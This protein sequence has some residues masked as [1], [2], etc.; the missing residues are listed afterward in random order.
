[1]AEN[2]TVVT[3]QVATLFL[4][5]GVGFVLFRRGSL[6]GAGIAQM[7]HLLLYVV[8]PC[9]V[10]N[11]LQSAWDAALLHNLLL[12]AA[13][14]ISAYLLYALAVL[15]LFRKKPPD[16]RA[17]LQFG[18]M[19]SNCGFMGLPLVQAVL[20]DGA[21]IYAALTVVCF[22]AF[23][24]IHGVALMGGREQ[25]SLKRAV[26]NPC[27]LGLAVGLPLFLLGVRLPAVLGDAVRFLSNLNTPLA[28][29]VIGGQMAQADLARTFRERELYGAACVKLILL[30]A[31]TALL[32][33]PFRLDP[34]MYA[35][36]VILCAAPT[37]GLTGM[38]A[39]RFGRSTA[40][41]AQLVTLSTLLS[42]L[43]LPPFAVLAKALAG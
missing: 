22:N 42:V 5:M 1:M 10:I 15:P 27:V 13:L 12:G 33:L 3:Q 32:L 9:I 21:M 8:T 43:T 38:F 19:Y 37:A 14:L 23:S 26:L 30:P 28:M 31:L 6:D 16:V 41:A 17:P 36:F 34:L 25:T 29:V 40:T 18:A 4:M 7:T 20:G 2:L 35:T 11:S 39:Q 24:W